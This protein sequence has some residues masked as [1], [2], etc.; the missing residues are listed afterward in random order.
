LRG[1]PPQFYKIDT[2]AKINFKNLKVD[3]N[4]CIQK[5]EIMKKISEWVLPFL[6]LCNLVVFF[7]DYIT[8]G[9]INF[10]QLCIVFGLMPIA[11]KSTKFKFSNSKNFT[12]F[13][14]LMLVLAGSMLI[15]QFMSN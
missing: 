15:L 11:V 2:S 12:Y 6:V 8:T 13:S 14:A 10:Y 5:G 3:V 1:F 4:S 9:D 7:K